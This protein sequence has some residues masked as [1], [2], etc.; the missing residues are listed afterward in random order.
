MHWPQKYA[1]RSVWTEARVYHESANREARLAKASLR[2]RA[3]ANLE[4]A[5]S[6][7]SMIDST[8]RM[9]AEVAAID[10]EIS[11]LRLAA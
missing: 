7:A 1:L 6:V 8:S 9:L 5:R 11:A 3:I 10:A 2:A 4:D